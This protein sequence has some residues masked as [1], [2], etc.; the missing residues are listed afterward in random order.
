MCEVVVFFLENS[1]SW[2]LWTEPLLSISNLFQEIFSYFHWFFYYFS[3]KMIFELSLNLIGTFFLKETSMKSTTCTQNLHSYISITYT[4]YSLRKKE[5]KKKIVYINIF[6]SFFHSLLF[7]VSPSTQ[8]VNVL[9]LIIHFKMFF[10]DI[11][12]FSIQYESMINMIAHTY[13]TLFLL[14]IQ[15]E[16][17]IFSFSPLFWW[18]YIECNQSTC[19]K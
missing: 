5:E 3:F 16:I 19:E 2:K 6:I 18:F 4:I 9:S 12:K 10:F 17:I 7:S 1:L 14:E 13:F 15:S 8:L 11:W